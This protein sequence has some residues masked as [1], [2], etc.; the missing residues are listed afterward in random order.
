MNAATRR[1]RDGAEHYRDGFRDAFLGLWGGLSDPG[2][3]IETALISGVVIVTWL[4]VHFR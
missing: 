3:W 2:V 1:L 4:A